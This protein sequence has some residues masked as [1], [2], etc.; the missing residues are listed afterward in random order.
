MIIFFLNFI[1][2]IINLFSYQSA[3]EL[4]L[5]EM[6]FN[7][8]FNDLTPDQI[9]GI[10][11]CFV[12]QE[13]VS[14]K[15]LEKKRWNFK[16]FQL[17][18][19]FLNIL[20]FSLTFFFNKKPYKV[21]FNQPFKLF[22]SSSYPEFNVFPNILSC[23]NIAFSSHVDREKRRQNCR[24]NSLDRYD[25]WRFVNV[26]FIIFNGWLIQNWNTGISPVFQKC[27]HFLS[28]LIALFWIYF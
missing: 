23:T 6:I 2:L 12:F 7:G 9:A 5:T 24:K 27:T 25:K 4:L 10:M 22:G 28:L 17:F 13:K 8:V 21:K 18:S 26:I 20:L 14:D 16:T 15:K 1:I 11:S 3:D 19:E